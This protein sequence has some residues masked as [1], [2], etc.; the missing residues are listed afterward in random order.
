[1][2]YYTLLHHF[3]RGDIKYLLRC[4][5]PRSQKCTIRVSYVSAN[6]VLT[7]IDNDQTGNFGSIVRDI[8]GDTDVPFTWTYDSPNMKL[9][10]RAPDG[11]AFTP[12][13]ETGSMVVQVVA[14]PSSQFS[15]NTTPIQCALYMAAGDNYHCSNPR[16]LPIGWTVSYSDT[17]PRELFGQKITPCSPDKI[18]DQSA[19]RDLF[20]VPFPSING[21]KSIEHA[22]YVDPDQT[23]GPVEYCKRFF[24]PVSESLPHNFT[25]GFGDGNPIDNMVAPFKFWSG[26]QMMKIQPTISYSG[27]PYQPIGVITVD[28]GVLPTGATLS[29]G[30]RLQMDMAHSREL[31]FGMPYGD[32]WHMRE[33]ADDHPEAADVSSVYRVSTLTYPTSTLASVYSSLGDDFS[34]MRYIS[35]PYL[36]W[37]TPE[38]IPAIHRWVV[39]RTSANRKRSMA[40]RGFKATPT[41]D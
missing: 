6:G 3:W 26:S 36:D 2:C 33:V 39:E 5:S 37:A 20:G 38:S 31:N 1:M 15:P 9:H 14:A 11:E 10:V 7:A 16:K 30:G 18:V 24:G 23:S 21:G 35:A 34:L 17:V 32:I 25:S 41:T 4:F 19:V 22:N 28:A 29:E 12:A 8:V 40:K 27:A 13:S